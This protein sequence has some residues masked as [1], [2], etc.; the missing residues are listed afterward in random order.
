M[1]SLYSKTLNFGCIVII[2]TITIIITTTL[3][4]S[5]LQNISPS[6]LLTCFHAAIQKIKWK[7]RQKKKYRSK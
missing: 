2:I 5:S 4:M 3:Y 7:A 1:E 6:V